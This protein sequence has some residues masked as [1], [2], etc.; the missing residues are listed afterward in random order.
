MKSEVNH[1][2]KRIQSHPS[3]ALW[4]GNNENEGNLASN[5]FN[6]ADNFEVYKADYIK[7]YIDTVRDEMRRI[8]KNANFVDSSPSNGIETDSEGYVSLDPGSLIYGDGVFIWSLVH[9]I[10]LTLF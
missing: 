9:K 7:L 10:H 5:Y 3:L 8:T 2:V 1:Q 4:G 6:T